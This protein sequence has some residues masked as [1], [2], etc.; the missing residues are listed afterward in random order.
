MDN[1]RQ[2]TQESESQATGSSNQGAGNLGSV[3]QVSFSTSASS[4]AREDQDGQSVVSGL[5]SATGQTGGA[6]GAGSTGGNRLKTVTYKFM[7]CGPLVT[8]VNPNRKEKKTLW[9]RAY[10]AQTQSSFR[11]LAVEIAHFEGSTDVVY[12]FRGRLHRSGEMNVIESQLWTRSS[13]CVHAFHADVTY[14]D[15]VGMYTTRYRLTDET[16][17][18]KLATRI[19][20]V[21][22]GND[23]G[24]NPGANDRAYSTVQN[25]VKAREFV[26]NQDMGKDKEVS[27]FRV[28]SKV[29]HNQGLFT[30]AR[31]HADTDA[32]NH[33]W[34]ARPLNPAGIHR[35]IAAFNVYNEYSDKIRIGELAVIEIRP[36]E[37]DYIPVINYL[38][39]GR[40]ACFAYDFNQYNGVDRIPHLTRAEP[41]GLEYRYLIRDAINA[42]LPP[43][44]DRGLSGLPNG[45]PVAPGNPV[46]G[47]VESD[48]LMALGIIARSFPIKVDVESAAW[49]HTVATFAEKFRGVDEA[50][51]HGDSEAGR[52][53]NALVHEGDVAVPSGDLSCCMFTKLR[54]QTDEVVEARTLAHKIF[55][56]TKDIVVMRRTAEM[57]IYAMQL[58]CRQVGLTIP[59]MFPRVPWATI[60][61]AGVPAPVNEDGLRMDYLDMLGRTNKANEPTVMWQVADALVGA[62]YG[63]KLPGSLMVIPVGTRRAGPRRVP[64]DGETNIGE[65]LVSVSGVQLP[66]DILQESA[67]GIPGV[68]HHVNAMNREMVFQN[69]GDGYEVRGFS[70][71]SIE[72]SDTGI[73]EFVGNPGTAMLGHTITLRRDENEEDDDIWGVS[74]GQPAKTGFD[75]V[76]GVR[77]PHVRVDRPGASPDNMF[78][79]IDD[80]VLTHNELYADFEWL[81]SRELT[82]VLPNSNY[83]KGIATSKDRKEKLAAYMEAQVK[84]DEFMGRTSSLLTPRKIKKSR[85]ED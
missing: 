20:S 65:C 68:H 21:A 38:L 17:T 33:T 45:G 58:A 27:A 66:P 8:A 3:A 74:A 5:T 40:V 16:E 76:M 56:M 60:H 19:A 82:L 48:W 79:G 36:D 47:R 83:G 15:N 4:G 59:I 29:W 37:F 42:N 51:E 6:P 70:N 10:E 81:S 39:G 28:W 9:E 26:N 55:H 2:D 30:L 57:C 32:L 46:L 35:E 61:P 63:A 77:I 80:R 1:N 7:K 78:L 34:A 75:R 67:V 13:V 24:V 11:P 12:P 49:L 41:N 62:L 52:A 14:R 85:I 22:T 64:T 23:A 72:T 84:T 18:Q 31:I 73:E 43:V 69:R 44:N 53:W 50:V 71:C 25:N 54:D